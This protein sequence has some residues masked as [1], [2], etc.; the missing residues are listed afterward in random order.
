MSP[1]RLS[2]KLRVFLQA[3]LSLC[4]LGASWSIRGFLCLL[5]YIHQR[6][7]S[8]KDDLADDNE[9]HLPLAIASDRSD[10]AG[11]GR[12]GLVRNVVFQRLTEN[13][14][15]LS[16]SSVPTFPSSVHLREHV[17]LLPIAGNNLADLRSQPDGL[18]VIGHIT[19]HLTSLATASASLAPIYAMAG[20]RSLKPLTPI[21]PS[22]VQ[23]YEPDAI[24]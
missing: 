24:M 2:L 19:R 17:S 4:R 3:L 1:R 22:D 7:H 10:Q 16:Y 12:E 18:S 6:R 9:G 15:T 13:E 20:S 21:V 23:H 14:V 5:S 8:S 11:V